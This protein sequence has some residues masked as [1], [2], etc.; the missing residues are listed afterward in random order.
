[1]KKLLFLTYFCFWICMSLLNDSLIAQEKITTPK[2]DLELISDKELLSK[3]EA[4]PENTWLKLPPSKV[5]GDIEW[6]KGSDN[7]VRGPQVRDYCNKMVWAPERK[8]AL[9]AGAGHNAPVTNDVWEYDMASNTWVCLYA[10]DWAF[11]G[12]PKDQPEKAAEILKGRIKVNGTTLTTLSG[13]PLRPAHTW[14]G[15]TYDAEKRQMVFWDAHRGLVFTPLFSSNPL[16]SK[17]LGIGEL[18]GPGAHAFLFDPATRKW[19]AWK[20]APKAWESSRLEYIPDRKALWLHSGKTYLLEGSDT[21][22]WKDLGVTGG[23]VNGA[24]SAYDPESK[25]IVAVLNKNTYSFSFETNQW[26]LLQEGKSPDAVVPESTFCYDTVSKRFVLIT[27]RMTPSLWLFDLKKNE[28]VDPK[29]SG[30]V[31]RPGTLAC[32]YDQARQVTALY[33]GVVEGTVRKYS[34]FVYRGVKAEK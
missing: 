7:L 3:I 18:P 28:W 29:P 31:P 32:Y 13:A 27:G 17:T 12:I 1:M 22:D 14:W 11:D 30:D 34:V 25:T 23:P 4:L 21:A 5:V 6:L 16:M 9:Y 2:V 10:W 26:K 24:L 19:S 15:L 33:T 8:R 20:D